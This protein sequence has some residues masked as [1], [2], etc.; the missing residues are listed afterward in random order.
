MTGIA[1]FIIHHKKTVLVFFALLALISAVL[2]PFV[3]VNYNMEDY[4]QP[5][6]QSTRSLDIMS[7]EFS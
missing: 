5:E 6:A 4:L 7:G 3:N 2:L 1:E